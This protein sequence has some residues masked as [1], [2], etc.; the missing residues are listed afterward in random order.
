MMRIER[1]TIRSR[2]ATIRVD[3][4]DIATFEG[5]TIATA[6]LQH[7]PAFRRDT[8]GRDRGLFCNMGSCSECMV[9]LLPSR[10]RVRACITAIA[11]GMEVSTHG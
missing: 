9:T 6:M 5:E 11:D 7:G 1:D 8:A 2:A 4:T 10:R 3:G